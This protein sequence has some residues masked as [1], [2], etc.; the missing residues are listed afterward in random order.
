MGKKIIIFSGIPGFQVKSME[1]YG[2]TIASEIIKRYPNSQN[3]P[4]EPWPF[5]KFVRPKILVQFILRY[6]IYP[7]RAFFIGL[8]NGKNAIYFVTDHANAGILCFVPQNS[9]K[10]VTVHD[11]GSLLPIN[12]L[13]Y[14]TSLEHRIIRL[15]SYFFKKP[16]IIRADKIITDSNFIRNQVNETLNISMDKIKTIPIGLQKNLFFT[17]NRNEARN[18]MQLTVSYVLMTVGYPTPRKNV[19]TLIKA[20]EKFSKTEEDFVL[21]H[22]GDIGAN[23]IKYLSENNLEKYVHIIRD[24]SIQEL[25]SCYQ[26]AD[27]YLFP[28]LYEGFGLPVIEAMACGCPVIASNCASLPEVVSDSG[29]L[30]DPL[31][32]DEWV[33]KI[34]LLLNN[35]KLRNKFINNG[36]E[37]VKQY[38]FKNTVNDAI[39][40]ITNT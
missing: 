24:I 36:L 40:Y 30:V 33:E 32:I 34:K 1:V 8:K 9:V 14:P 23:A 20:I 26:G 39:N 7:L 35:T 28:S 29:L 3:I 6:A 11:L 16:G 10:I 2:N 5:L 13:P 38:D 15:L 18:Q 27:I 21:I 37:R 31:N 17:S 4:I 19:I 22:V 12:K 25:R